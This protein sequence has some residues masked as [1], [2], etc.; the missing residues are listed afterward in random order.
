MY[1]NTIRLALLV[2]L[3]I[4]FGSGC[5]NAARNTEELHSTRDRDMTV[6][7]VQREIRRGMSS[8]EVAEALGS[9]N[10]VQSDDGGQQTWIYDK[11]ATEASYSRSSGSTGGILGGGV[12]PGESLILGLITGNY[13]KNTGAYAS[14]QRT[15]T[16]VIKFDRHNRVD[17]FSYHS[18]KF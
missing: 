7:I 12:I 10:I 9:P 15:L 4:G 5:V 14:T 16:V 1:R 18:S 17:A 6:G 11:I 8:T 3:I 13:D 2:L